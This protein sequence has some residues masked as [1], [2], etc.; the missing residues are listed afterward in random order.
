MGA[1]F[2]ASQL[3]RMSMSETLHLHLEQALSASKCGLGPTRAG[4]PGH[5]VQ[6]YRTDAYLVDSVVKFLADGVRVGQPIIVIATEAHRNAFA[7]GLRANGVDPDQLLSGRV[8]VWLDARETLT[9]FMEGGLPNRE[10][11]AA[12]V[13][14]VFER[15]LDNR[16]YLIV[17]A[18]GEMVDLLWKDGNAQGAIKLEQLWN[19]L[20]D[21]FKYSLLCGY[22]LD[23]FLHPAAAEGF[24]RICDHHTHALPLEPAREIVA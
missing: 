2:D 22:A 1:Y 21:R 11:F 18:Y 6:F 24:R 14:S 10:L 16:Y 9:A 8:A 3:T 20:A 15:I 7:G 4:L 23:N 5:D 13:G 12:T 19:E 17:R